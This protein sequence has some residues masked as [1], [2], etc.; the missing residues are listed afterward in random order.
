MAID[1]SRVRELAGE[2]RASPRERLA[3]ARDIV[4]SPRQHG[5]SKFSPTHTAHISHSFGHA[6]AQSALC[7]RALKEKEDATTAPLTRSQR[8]T[9]SSLV[10]IAA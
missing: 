6:E 3:T 1:D 4:A 7:R 9:Q 8:L 2:R 5:P 10:T